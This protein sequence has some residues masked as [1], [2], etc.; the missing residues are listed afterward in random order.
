MSMLLLLLA[1]IIPSAHRYW[2]PNGVM[3]HHR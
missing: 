2:L 1:P 3:T